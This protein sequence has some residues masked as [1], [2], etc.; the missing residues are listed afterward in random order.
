MEVAGLAAAQVA[1]SMVEAGDFGLVSVVC[2]RGNNGGD[3]FVVARHLERWA[4]E[5]Q[6]F[7]V[8]DLPKEG[9]E[10]DVNMRILESIGREVQIIKPRDLDQLQAELSHSALI[11]DA[12]LGTGMDRNVDGAYADVIDIINYSHV[13]VLAIDI[14]SGINADTGA[15]MGT[16]IEAD[17]TVTF[18]HLKAGLLHYPGAQHAGEIV[19]VD[20]GLP[21]PKA[22]TAHD[23]EWFLATYPEIAGWLPSRSAD[24][25]KGS[26]GRLLCVA[27]CHR[28]TGA[29]MLAARASMRTGLGISVLATTASALSTAP[30]EEIIYFP[31]PE[32]E[33]GSIASSAI[34]E[35]ANQLERATAYLIGP[36]MTEHDDT[37]KFVHEFV[38]MI[39]KPAVIDADALNAISRNPELKIGNASECVLTPHPKELS[40][41]LGISTAEVQADRI[42]AAE[43]AR[44][45]F[46][47]SVVLKG[48]H[49]VVATIDGTTWII[50]C[51][52]PGMATAGTGD[53]LAGIIGGLLAQGVPAQHAAI[54]GTYL[55]ATAGDLA[56][57]TH[58]EDGMVASSIIEAL[59]MVLADIRSGEYTGSDLEE[60]ILDMGQTGP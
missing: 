3:G 1:A 42:A 56:A 44:D 28:M 57:F 31:L 25:N 26:M 4:I 19:L 50:P 47:C 49:S 22:G 32:T 16:A 8:G 6:V 20:I 38:G 43:K 14:P 23:T 35:F 41:L 40:R 58:G 29:A 53:V 21:E 37:V 33:S 46:G 5:T 45:K 51:G 7:L 48:A 12:I 34:G 59:P 9:S 2:G 17:A 54:A 30:P 52:N 10:A 36:G 24:A 55:H 13:P 15:V 39:D 18:G 11:V 27:G 60:M